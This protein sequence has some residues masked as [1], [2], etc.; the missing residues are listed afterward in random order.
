MVLTIPWGGSIKEYA[1]K[2][3]LYA[4]RRRETKN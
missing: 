1:V 4:K 3:S 2:I